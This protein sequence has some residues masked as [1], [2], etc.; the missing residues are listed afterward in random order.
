MLG[1]FQ[2]A[3]NLGMGFGQLFFTATY[4][5]FHGNTILLIVPGLLLA[6]Y[7]FFSGILNRPRLEQP[8]TIS[9][10][11]T[12]KFFGSPPLRC[13]YLAQLFS[14]VILWSVVFL[15]PDFLKG[16]GYGEWMAF[17]GGNFSYFLGAALGC[18]PVGHLRN[19]FSSSKV[20]VANFF[21]AA[22]CYYLLMFLPA[23]SPFLACLLL[24]LIGGLLGGIMPLCLAIGSDFVPHRRGMVSACLMGLV[25]IVSE[26]GGIG[27]ISL[28]TLCFA[29]DG[30]RKALACFGIFLF[31]G[32]FFASKLI[33]YEKEKFTLLA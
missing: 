24:F 12:L 23:P 33:R 9:L 31:I 20:I 25:W 4:E 27:S 1:I 30:P 18:L 26:G 28:L 14:Q 15:L 29:T 7:V 17:G 6:M 22:I 5:F 8:Q 11:Y 21:G 2:M 19:R 32:A 10:S 13:L 16:R 3:G